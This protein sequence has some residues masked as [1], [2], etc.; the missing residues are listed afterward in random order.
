MSRTVFLDLKTTGL[1]VS[2]HEL[3]EIGLIVREPG[4]QDFERQ[5]FIRPGSLA[6]ADPGALRMNHYRRRTR[7]L[8]S[9]LDAA[10]DA[11][12]ADPAPSDQQWSLPKPAAD[13]VAELTDC[14]TIVGHNPWFD[15]GFLA[16]FLD[17]NSQCHSWDYH[18]RDIGSLVTGWV[19]G[20][21]SAA[22]ARIENGEQVGGRGC[23]PPW[24]ASA[25]L[26]DMARAVGISPETYELHTALGDARLERDVYDAVM[27][28][29]R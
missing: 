26:A 28:G 24:P 4:E 18:L 9:P 2:R 1:D 6:G 3:W 7:D 12:L 11:A 19:A 21:R 29:E 10:I 5:W 13:E 17:A 20:L 27:A 16:K 22:F 14:A 8:L 23:L 15:A 25:K